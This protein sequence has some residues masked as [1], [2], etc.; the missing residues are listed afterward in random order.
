M[1]HFALRLLN[2][3]A[4]LGTTAWLARAPDWEPLVTFIGLLAALVGQEIWP[5]LKNEDNDKILFEKFLAEFPS[6]GDS[7]RFLQDQDIGAPFLSD[8][9][10]ELDA[11][12]RN[13]G[14]AEH[15]F[16]NEKL[17]TQRK[18]LFDLAETFRNELSVSVYPGGGGFLTMDI[19]DLEDRPEKLKRRDHLNEM[20]TRVFR[21]HQELI[22][23]GK[24]C[25]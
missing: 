18:K 4:L 14:N 9:L 19:K 13:W 16:R 5:V 7:A 22:R 20:A 11:F 6:I 21:E 25:T 3:L 15:E 8:A 10:K 24:K 12:V 1:K 2:L 23:L 17:E